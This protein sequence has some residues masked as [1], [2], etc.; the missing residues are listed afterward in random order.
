MITAAT[1]NVAVKPVVWRGAMMM[2]CGDQWND[3]QSREQALA[4]VICARQSELRWKCV[5]MRAENTRSQKPP[6]V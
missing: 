4:R 5:S 2:L 3:V 6:Q 1:I